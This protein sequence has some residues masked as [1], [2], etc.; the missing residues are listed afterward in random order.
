MAETEQKI[1]QKQVERLNEIAKKYS[2]LNELNYLRIAAKAEVKELLEK[3][4]L[5]KFEEIMVATSYFTA[6][7]LC[8]LMVFENIIKVN[9]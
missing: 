9:K 1:S 8:K 2:T 5:T 4:N 6:C 7:A 3:D